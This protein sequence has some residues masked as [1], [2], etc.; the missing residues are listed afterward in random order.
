[1]NPALLAVVTARL[2]RSVPCFQ[3]SLSREPRDLLPLL[4][5]LPTPA[6]H[7]IARP[8]RLRAAG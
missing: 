4:D 7:A 3:L 8:T 1:M 2:G 5:T 6:S